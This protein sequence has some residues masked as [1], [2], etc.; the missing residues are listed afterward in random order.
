MQVHDSQGPEPDLAW[1]GVYESAASSTRFVADMSQDCLRL[2]GMLV[3]ADPP[4][5]EGRRLAISRF[6]RKFG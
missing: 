6:A 3:K 1:P 5:Q 4:T 2:P